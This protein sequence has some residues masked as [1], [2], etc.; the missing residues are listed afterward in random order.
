MDA[1]V[2]ITAC[3][4]QKIRWWDLRSQKPII[5]YAVDGAIGS[6]ELNSFSLIAGDPISDPGILSIA[7][8]KSAYFFDGSI[9][10]SLL[11][12]VDFP[13]K[14]ASV[15]INAHAGRFVTGCAED[16]W[17]RVYDLETDEELGMIFCLFPFSYPVSAVYNVAH[18]H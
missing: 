18:L 1:S 8:G 14:V 7:A 3:E 10:G 4:D 15:A 17:A 16:T 6:C 2:I 12:K 13:Y 5:E 9:P 11:K